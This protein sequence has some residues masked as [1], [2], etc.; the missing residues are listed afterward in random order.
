[1]LKEMPSFISERTNEYLKNT[2]FNLIGFINGW[3]EIRNIPSKEKRI[4]I[5]KSTLDLEKVDQEYC[6]YKIKENIV[7]WVLQQQPIQIL[8]INEKELWEKTNSQLNITLEIS[9]SD[10]LRCLNVEY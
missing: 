1:M 10:N 8:M 9:S 7:K 4:P 2:N 5:N 6:Q 3:K